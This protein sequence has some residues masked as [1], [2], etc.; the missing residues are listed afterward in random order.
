MRTAR[1]HSGVD[2]LRILSKFETLEKVTMTK[3]NTKPSFATQSVEELAKFISESRAQLSDSRLNLAGS[4]P[5]HTRNLRRGI[6]R[7]LTALS[8][9]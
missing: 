8:A 2:S 5:H 1:S 3:K 4:K 7:A 6:A 9:K